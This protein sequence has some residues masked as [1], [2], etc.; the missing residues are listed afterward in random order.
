MPLGSA[1]E[2]S[3]RSSARPGRCRPY[4]RGGAAAP[5]AVAASMLTDATGDETGEGTP[6]ND[7]NA[8]PTQSKGGVKRK[9]GTDPALRDRK[10]D[11][12]ADPNQRRTAEGQPDPNDPNARRQEGVRLVPF[13]TV[14]PM[15]PDWEEDLRRGGEEHD[16]PGIRLHPNYHG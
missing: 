13:G 1:T 6:E 7:P 8:D 3:E 5:A 9:E 16:M 4:S 11:Q 15:L 10:T 14:N 2:S 12:P